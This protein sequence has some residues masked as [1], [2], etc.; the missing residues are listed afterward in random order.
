MVTKRLRNCLSRQEQSNQLTGQYNKLSSFAR[1]FYLL[2]C[3]PAIV[4]LA[5]GDPE[6]RCDP[7]RICSHYRRGRKHGRH[8]L[9]RKGHS[10]QGPKANFAPCLHRTTSAWPLTQSTH[11]ARIALREDCPF[12]PGNLP[13]RQGQRAHD[14]DGRH[15][16]T[17]SG[18]SSDFDNLKFPRFG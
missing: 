4:P 17:S 16:R 12:V 15:S 7:E 18:R 2:F 1:C 5:A 6:G 11:R 9:R 10:E 3:S 8:C 14:L 13:N